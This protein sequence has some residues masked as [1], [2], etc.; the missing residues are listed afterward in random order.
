MPK[1]NWLTLRTRF[2]EPLAWSRDLPGLNPLFRTDIVFKDADANVA[3]QTGLERTLSQ[4]RPDVER[5]GGD[6]APFQAAAYER[7]CEVICRR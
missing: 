6:V 2:A 7:T 1:W 3:R 5:L 4:S